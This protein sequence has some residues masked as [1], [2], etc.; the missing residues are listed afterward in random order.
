M[1]KLG[2]WAIAP[3]MFAIPAQAQTYSPELLKKSV[4]LED[5]QAVVASL[6]HEVLEVNEDENLVVGQDAD[7]AA[8]FLFG[9]ACNVG[10]VPGCQGINM[11]IRY[12]LA[13]EVT[14]ES[15]AEANYDQAAVQTWVDFEE[16]V[17]GVTRYQVLDYGATMANIRENVRVL[18]DVAP[19]SAAVAAGI[20][21]EQEQKSL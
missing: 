1:V 21:P 13:P 9:T 16:K 3:L 12:R 5:L 14:Y 7:G 19:V 2:I 10:G 11:Q 17:L 6:D 20:N 8:Y 18:L 4:T 15:V